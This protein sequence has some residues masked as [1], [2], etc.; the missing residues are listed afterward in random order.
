[1]GGW[2][3]GWALVVALGELDDDGRLVELMEGGGR[4]EGPLQ[5]VHHDGDLDLWVWVGGWV[6]GWEEEVGREICGW[7]DWEE[8]DEAVGMGWVGGWVG[9]TDLAAGVL[10]GSGGVLARELGGKQEATLYFIGVGRWVGGWVGGRVGGELLKDICCGLSIEAQPIHPPTHPSTSL[11]STDARQ[12]RLPPT[13][14]T[15]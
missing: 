6:G 11:P 15:T 2:V 10:L 1:M 4:G 13:Q 12:G 8:E 14:R 7:V 5:R 9:G 3:G